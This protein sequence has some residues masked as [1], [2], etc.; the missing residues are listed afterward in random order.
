MKEKPPN[1]WDNCSLK[2]LHVFRPQTVIALRGLLNVFVITE[3]SLSS[4]SII[5]SWDSVSCGAETVMVEKVFYSPLMRN[6]HLV[7]S[8]ERQSYLDTKD[9]I[10]AVAGQTWA[11]DAN[12]LGKE[13][14]WLEL[15][16][17]IESGGAF[18]RQ[19]QV[20]AGLV[21]IL[22]AWVL[23]PALYYQ[24]RTNL[25]WCAWYKESQGASAPHS[26]AILSSFSAGAL[27]IIAV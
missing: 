17:L 11:L 19:L 21:V 2:F 14:R 7:L 13:R 23:R 4:N 24:N 12:N 20:A 6:P 1:W 15:L 3:L 27:R 8:V 16:F 18:H 22:C 25:G 10:Y 26:V 5:A 9:G